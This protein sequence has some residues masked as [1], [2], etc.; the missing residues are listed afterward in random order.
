LHA[1][2]QYQNYYLQNLKKPECIVAPNLRIRRSI[3]CIP[4][5]YPLNGSSADTYNS[6]S[7]NDDLAWAAMWMYRF[8]FQHHRC[9]EDG[10]VAALV[11]S[12]RDLG[13][14]LLFC[15]HAA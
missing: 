1:A 4:P 3:N 11:P 5:T 6:T 13:A 14:A 15:L 8:G 7:Y 10:A 9:C 12:S 2:G